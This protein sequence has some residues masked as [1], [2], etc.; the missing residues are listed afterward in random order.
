MLESPRNAVITGAARGIG[1]AIAVRLA[2]DGCN[3]VVNDLPVNQELLDTLVNEIESSER[4]AVSFAGDV[5]VEETVDALVEKC[6]ATYG[7]LDIMICNAG[8][9]WVKPMLDCT[10]EDMQG[11]FDTNFRSVW[12]GYQ[13]AARQMIKQGT[14]G[15]IIGSGF[16]HIILVLDFLIYGYPLM[17]VYSASKFAIRGLTQA[18]DTPTPTTQEWGPQRITVNTCCPGMIELGKSLALAAGFVDIEPANVWASM[19]ALKRIGD[20]KDLVGFVSYLA[21]EES[22]VTGQSRPSQKVS[23]I[24]SCNR[25][26]GSA[27][28]PSGCVE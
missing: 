24:Y 9:C 10:L 14:G 18:A 8:N 1:R 20:T 16:I 28:L 12:L 23:Q 19:A 3:V 22:G 2:A 4:K 11:L 25:F 21:S 13:C 15:R 6:V 5:T 17:S 7:S 27:S 26:S